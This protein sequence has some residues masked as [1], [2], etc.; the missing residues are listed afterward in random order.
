MIIG[1]TGTLGAGKGT[2]VDHLVRTRGFRH[3]SVRS[4]LTRELESAG[5]PVNR[6]T[7]TRLANDLRSTHHPAVLI[8]RLYDEARDAGGDAVI[9]SI[10]TPGEV[11]FLR[12]TGPFVLVAVDAP[13]ETRYARITERAS[14]TDDVDL[15]TF[16]QNEEREMR[17]TDPTRQNLSACIAR[18]D[19]VFRNDGS[20]RD[21]EAAIEAWL[22]ERDAS[23]M[24]S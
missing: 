5:W 2:L 24:A 10:R 22:E 9:E 7:M 12:A 15:E 23:G 8:E 17:A 19:K 13:L 11:D 18:A 1:I 20:V 16:R 14:S 3:Y 4:L 6:D 21:F